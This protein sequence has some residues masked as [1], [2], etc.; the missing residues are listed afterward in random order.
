M[1][2]AFFSVLSKSKVS[3]KY[4]LVSDKHR[5]PFIVPSW[6]LDGASRWKSMAILLPHPNRRFIPTV[7]YFESFHAYSKNCVILDVSQ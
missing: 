1:R 7:F 2:V 6:G 4:F 3:V 5:Y